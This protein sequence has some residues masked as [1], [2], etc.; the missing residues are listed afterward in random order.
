MA[1]PHNARV[2]KGVAKSHIFLG[3][4]KLKAFPDTLWSEYNPS[5]TLAWQVAGLMQELRFEAAV[6]DP[7][8]QG[9][10]AHKKQPH[11][12]GPPYDSRYSPTVESYEGGCFL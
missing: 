12:L 10:L 6:L 4:Q 3:F 2:Y 5:N 7:P 1:C 11:L 8:L 9:Y